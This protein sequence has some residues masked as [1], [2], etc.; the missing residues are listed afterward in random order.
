MKPQKLLLAVPRGFCG[1]VRRAIDVVDLAL[2]LWPPPIYVRK[3]IV[4][5]QHIVE[6]FK[7]RGVLFV[8]EVDEVPEGA[9]VI[10]SAHGIAPQVKSLA[11][12]RR[13]R[14]IDATCPLV[15][16]VHLEAVRY[17]RQ[18]MSIILIGHPGHDE[19]VGTMGEAP[20]DIRLVSTVEDAERVAVADA[21]LVAVI[22]QT[23]LSVGDTQEILQILKRRFPHLVTPARDDICYA[24]QNRQTAV[25]ILAQQADLVLVLG[26]SNSSNSVRLKEVAERTGTRAYLID[27]SKG[28]QPDWLAESQC[29]GLTA[30]AS[31]PEYLVQDTVAYLR[32]RGLTDIQEVEVIHEDESFALPPNLSRGGLV[33]LRWT[34]ESSNRPGIPRSSQADANGQYS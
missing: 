5:N 1:G 20:A 2:T 31:V 16:K 10:F 30:G 17:A 25:K 14:V 8:G 12:A 26:S 13:L 22:T 27:D 24:T 7:A 32:A 3:E 4:H 33:Q 19:V 9:L 23:T 6:D 11:A 15:T 21:S 34:E 18:G 28:I 29:V